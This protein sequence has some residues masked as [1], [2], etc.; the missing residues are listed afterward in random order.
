MN[1]VDVV[2]E[3]L[4]QTEDLEEKPSVEYW[5]DV[6]DYASLQGILDSR[7]EDGYRVIHINSYENKKYNEMRFYIVYEKEVS[8]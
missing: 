8:R 1:K 4:T 2:D 5:T 6:C 3:H 7:S